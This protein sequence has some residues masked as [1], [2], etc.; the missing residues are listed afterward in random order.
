MEDTCKNI[1]SIELQDS[2]N[3]IKEE[4]EK[5]IIEKINSLT[6]L[7]L[8]NIR[9]DKEK[10]NLNQFLE[11]LKLDIKFEKE[12]NSRYNGMKNIF[13]DLYDVSL[14]N[15]KKDSKSIIENIFNE[16]MNSFVEQI[17]AFIERAKNE[18]EQEI[19]N[20]IISNIEKLTS[21]QCRELNIEQYINY[22]CVNG[23]Q[24]FEIKTNSFFNDIKNFPKTKDFY[25]LELE[26]IKN[27][28]DKITR[29][30]LHIKF[31]NQPPWPKNIEEL[32]KEQ[33]IDK[34]I[35]NKNYILFTIDKRPYE[36]IAKEDDKIAI[37]NV[38]VEQNYR[39]EEL[40]CWR[41]SNGKVYESY[42]TNIDHWFE[43]NGQ[44]LILQNNI[45]YQNN[46]SDGGHKSI[47]GGK[48][49]PRPQQKMTTLSINVGNPWNIKL[50]D[51]SGDV[52]VNIS[53]DNHDMFVSG[54]NGSVQNIKLQLI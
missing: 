12:T 14:L 39:R 36:V 46:W 1:F 29:E 51:I 48:K 54:I 21:Q 9:K 27:F 43:P 4:T 41:N 53:N 37:P 33:K 28:I 7:E 20:S 38:K 35:P 49:P 5:I 3:K 22:N 18:S 26:L 40:P 52:S 15:L 45:V 11:E 19:K 31:T 24:K 44:I 23:I 8:S 50:F 42:K 30:E 16:K 25:L 47:L 10:K 32:K 17:K 13:K 2:V 34:L 6:L